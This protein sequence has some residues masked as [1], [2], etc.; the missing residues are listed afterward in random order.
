MQKV[1]D[2]EDCEREND[3]KEMNEQEGVV[4][5]DPNELRLHGETLWTKSIMV[6]MG[7]TMDLHTGE[8]EEARTDII[9]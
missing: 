8:D 6:N 1:E 7:D 4:E 2:E 5:D 9:M 3:Q